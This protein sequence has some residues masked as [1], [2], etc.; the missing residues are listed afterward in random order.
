MARRSDT[1]IVVAAAAAIGF[2]LL[3]RGAAAKGKKSMPTGP[4]V[5][6]K[7]TG[8][9]ST[10]DWARSRFAAALAEVKKR[11]GEDL[12]DEAATQIALSLL[13]HWSIE[14]GAGANEYNFNVGNITAYGKQAYTTLR[15]ISGVELP[16]RSFDTLGDGV[17]AYVDLLNSS[18]YKA[19]AALLAQKPEETDWWIALGKA[20]WFNPTKAKPPSTWDQAAASYAARRA[21]LAQY[22]TVS[23]QDL[24]E[25]GD[26]FDVDDEEDDTF[27]VAG[28]DVDGG[29]GEEGEQ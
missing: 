9:G 23:G 5:D 2:F 11:S 25:G 13:T 21:S 24:A 1:L 26:V 10:A 20:G 19:A 27:D 29:E 15:D 7:K 18:N 4:K 12:T 28:V 22:A 17:A 8:P 3:A 16:F 14:T 6:A